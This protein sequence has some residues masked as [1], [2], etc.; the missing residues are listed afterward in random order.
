MKTLILACCLVLAAFDP[1]AAALDAA[2]RAQRA[3][4]DRARVVISSEIV[5]PGLWFTRPITVVVARED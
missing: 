2:T 1:E 3:A 4:E 5:A